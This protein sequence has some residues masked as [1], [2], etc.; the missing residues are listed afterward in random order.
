MDDKDF[1]GNPEEI[2][3]ELVAAFL[4]GNVNEEEMSSIA[5]ALANDAELAEL[6]ALS[7]L[8][9]MEL[10]K[11]QRRILPMRA[12]AA[13]NPENLCSFECEAFILR[14]FNFDVDHWSL[15]EEAKANNWVREEGT[16]LHH[17]GKLL[18]LKGVLVER[19]YDASIDDLEESVEAG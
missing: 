2:S 11:E 13:A 5:G 17:V 6:L 9:D 10:D 12:L 8:I 19:K 15:L 1:K 18:E 4:D 16:P 3:D 14:H 7:P